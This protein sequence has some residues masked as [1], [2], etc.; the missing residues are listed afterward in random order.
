MIS[1]FLIYGD[2]RRDEG[3]IGGIRPLVRPQG[4][5][6]LNM[7]EMWVSV[8]FMFAKVKWEYRNNMPSP[9]LVEPHVQEYRIN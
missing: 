4:G 2:Q 3:N 6:K 1:I 8:Y 5:A 9:C 7:C